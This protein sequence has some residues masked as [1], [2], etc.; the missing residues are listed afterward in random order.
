MRDEKIGIIDY[1]MGNLCS[2]SN[3]V[4][5][6][7]CSPEILTSPSE[8]EN[9]DRLILPGVGAFPDCMRN[10]TLKEFIA[11]LNSAVI[12]RKIPILGICLGMQAF[13]EFGHEGGVT[14][15]LGWIR[16][17]CERIQPNQPELRVPHIG[18]NT[19]DYAVD[20]PLFK[21]LRAGSHVYFVHS[22]HLACASDSD[23]IATAEHG[24]RIT[25]AVQRGNIFGTQFHPEKSQEPGLQI[26]KNFLEWPCLK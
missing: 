17:V 26:L 25:A 21:G 22:Y 23:V 1:G 18:W 15:G 14:K 11:P 3:A 24:C 4:A 7:G 20:S 2:V 6:W 13:A 16:G 9:C 5:Y 12:D 10:L 19:L 8:I